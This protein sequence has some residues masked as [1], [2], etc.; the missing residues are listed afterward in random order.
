M[1]PRAIGTN[2]QF[3]LPAGQE[4]GNSAVSVWHSAWLKHLH[5]VSIVVTG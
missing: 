5:W 1:L 4:L 2:A 3:V